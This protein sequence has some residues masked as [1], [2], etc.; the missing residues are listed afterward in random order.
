[1]K[2]VVTLT[3]LIAVA[4]TLTIHA[5]PAP[6]PGKAGYKSDPGFAGPGSTTAQLAEDDE[7]KN[8]TMRIPWFDENLKPW[9]DWKGRLQTKHGLKLGIAY[10]SLYQGTSEDTDAG[11]GIVRFSGSWAL[12]DRDGSNTGSLVFSVDNRHLYGTDYA[13]GDIA[14]GIDS[15]YLGIPGTLFT[16]I[17][18]VLGDLNWQ[19]K[20]ADG[21]AGLIVGRYDPNDFFD[22]LGYANP[23]TTFQNLVILFNGSIALPD[24]STG[25]GGGWWMTEEWYLKAAVNDANGVVTETELFDDAYELYS[26]AEIGWS[27]SA[28]E[29]YT[30]N[31]HVMG[32]HA[33][34]REDAGVEESWGVTLGGNWTTDD[35]LWMAFAKAGWSEGSAPLYNETVTIGALRRFAYRSDLVGL[36]ANWGA[37]ADS[38]LR[39]QYTGE[40][41]YRLQLAQ[42]LA[43]TPSLQLV[44]D[45]ALNPD[46]DEVWIGGLRVRLTL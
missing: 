18:T 13:P 25:I 42:N 1:M 7:E 10:T 3:M 45:P 11:S 30:K 14:F 37:P 6:R 15:G 12:V 9:F 28:A 44:V 17:D 24:W 38:S 21:T 39:D 29:R 20:L 36:A 34:E 33:D 46:E 8:P 2:R 19:Q 16:D 41:F 40:L 4:S 35:M 32:W 26:T 27:P 23:W 31:L 43:I 22:V 5:D